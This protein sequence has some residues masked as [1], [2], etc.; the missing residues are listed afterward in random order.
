MSPNQ[1]RRRE[2]TISARRDLQPLRQAVFPERAGGGHWRA[3][4]T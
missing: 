2:E 3:D 1:E 4:T